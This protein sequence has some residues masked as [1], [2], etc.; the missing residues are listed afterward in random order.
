M[1]D[2]G[3]Q[4]IKKHEGLR[5]K[6][7]KCSANKL[8][9]GYGRN[10]EDRGITKDEAVLLLKNDV[11]DHNRRLEE[12]LPWIKDIDNE[13]RKWVLYNM[14][15]NLGVKGLLGFKN[16][17]RM[18]KEGNYKGASEN[19]LLSK[20]ANQVGRRATQLSKQMRT[21]KWV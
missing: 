13:P 21:G 8:T 7:Y 11:E 5:L 9:I 19:M 15:F 1:D 20:W 2:R 6:P 17:L 4:Q 3:I 16:T 10:L 12:S 14:A 18:V